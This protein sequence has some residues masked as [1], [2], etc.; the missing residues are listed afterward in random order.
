MAILHLMVGLPCSGKTTCAQK[1]GRE[2]NALVLT[3]DVWH[4][5]L[6][7]DDVGQ[8]V[9]D[10]RHS[11]IEK[12]M[13]EVAERVLSLGCDVILDFG[14]WAREEREDFRR[15]AAALGV[16]FKLHYMEAPVDELFARLAV[17]N[18]LPSDRAFVIPREEM[19]RYLPI[20][21]PPTAEEL[22]R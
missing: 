18:A 2:Y 8:A 3:P 9:H 11:N 21:E 14:F 10:I 20:F 15:R 7:G 5:R 22:Q 6:F 16:D 19:E 12:I 17:R 4:L 13:W 1:L